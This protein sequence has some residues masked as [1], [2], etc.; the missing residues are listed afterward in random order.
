SGHEAQRAR[1]LAVLGATFVIVVL[2]M[3]A[4]LRIP[5]VKR[6]RVA[7]PGWPAALDGYRVVQLTDVHIGSIL[8]RRFARGLVE[9]CNA[10]QADAIAITGDLV[11]GRV[12]QLADDVAPF[13]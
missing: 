8:R 6:V 12:H 2:G 5:S 7:L 1:A 4:A 3:I 13:A 11:D 10:L 9:R